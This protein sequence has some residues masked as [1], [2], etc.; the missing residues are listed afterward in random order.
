MINNWSCVIWLTGL[1]ASGKTTL[2]EAFAKTYQNNFKFKI[3]DGDQIRKEFPHLGFSKED[4]LLHL[5]RI[6][7]MA[8]Q[9]EAKGYVVLVAVI[10]PYEESRKLAKSLCKKYFEVYISTPLE[11]CI[12]R[13]PKGLYKK[14]LNK[15]IFQFTGVSDPYEEP[16]SPDLKIDT[17]QESTKDSLIKIFNLIG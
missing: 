4:R 3:L 9:Y 2:S 11:V 14:A 13:D 8:S 17:S 6:A 16:L 10:S 15:E 12:A 5:H 1:S 7:E